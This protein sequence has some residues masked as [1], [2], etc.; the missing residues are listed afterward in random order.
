MIALPSIFGMNSVGAWQ[1][2]QIRRFFLIQT[3]VPGAVLMSPNAI[4]SFTLW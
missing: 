2:S 1:S 3:G 4:T